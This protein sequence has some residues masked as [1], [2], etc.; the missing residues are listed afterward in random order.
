MFVYIYILPF[1]YLSIHPSIH[2]CFHLLFGILWIRR[3]GLTKRLNE[4]L[5]KRIVMARGTRD[6]TAA[7][8]SDAMTTGSAEACV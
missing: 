6:I 3:G 5:L 7:A 4:T 2:V 8:L 1:I